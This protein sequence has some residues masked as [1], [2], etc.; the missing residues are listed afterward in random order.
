M[1]TVTRKGNRPREH[2][3][4]TKN[5]RLSALESDKTKVSLNNIGAPLT[6]SMDQAEA[7]KLGQPKRADPGTQVN[8]PQPGDDPQH[9]QV[10]KP[11]GASNNAK[12][13]TPKQTQNANPGLRGAPS[14]LAEE[15]AQRPIS[16]PTQEGPSV[17]RHSTKERKNIL[18]GRTGARLPVQQGDIRGTSNNSHRINA[19]RQP[20]SGTSL[21]YVGKLAVNTSCDDLRCHLSDVNIGDVAD[22]V[23]LNSRN[24][25]KETSFCISFNTSSELDKIFQAEIW[26]AGVIVRPF[27][28][29]KSS[30]NY[31]NFRGHHN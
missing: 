30:R 20:S 15:S 3:K 8:P 5:K 4:R 25:T 17:Y 21:V 28:P 27:R 23:K 12:D 22:V 29:F 31:R 19:A 24:K 11:A 16:R 9:I 13:G 2:C 26:P 18:R 7:G 10:N 14:Q 6:G 1:Y